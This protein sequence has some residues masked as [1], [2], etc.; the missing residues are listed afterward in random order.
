MTGV[1]NIL[2]YN[3]KNNP[4]DNIICIINGIFHG[5][6]Y[7]LQG[8]NH[9]Y[10]E[11]KIVAGMVSECMYYVCSGTIRKPA[12]TPAWHL[13]ALRHIRNVLL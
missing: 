7:T 6:F 4:I 9:R 13:I 12:T 11:E 8:R 1:C 10:H 2:K 3:V 5:I